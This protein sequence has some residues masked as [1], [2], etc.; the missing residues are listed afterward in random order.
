M[1]EGARMHALCN[2]FFLS[3]IPSVSRKNNKARDRCEVKNFETL[4]AKC[5]SLKCE[6]KFKVM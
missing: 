4:S 3:D 1:G 5:M 6:R 2:V